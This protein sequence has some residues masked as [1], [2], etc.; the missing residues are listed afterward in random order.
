MK[1]T[2]SRGQGVAQG[3]AVCV[4][5]AGLMRMKAFW[6]LFRRMNAVDEGGFRV[7]LEGR[8]S[9]PCCLPCATSR[10]SM[11]VRVSWPVVLVSP[12]PSRFKLGPCS[13]RILGMAGEFAE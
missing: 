2:A 11:D 12:L 5:P 7:A 6:S 8:T 9:N 3:D 4:K 13:T 1:G 10:W